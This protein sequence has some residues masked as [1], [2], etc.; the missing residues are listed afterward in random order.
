M[1]D[2]NVIY[3][4]QSGFQ[5]GDSTVNQLVDIYNTIISSLDKGKDVRF[6]FCDISKAFDKVWHKGLLSKL[7]TYG[8]SG[9]ILGWIENYL[10][11]R[12][13]KVVIDGFSSNHETVNAG[14]PQGSVLGPFLFLLY[15]NDICDDLVNNIRLFA[16][17]TSLYAIVE[18]GTTN[19]AQS[20]TNDLDLVDKWSKDWLVDFNPNKTVNVDFSRKN[21]A[22]PPIKFGENSPLIDQNIFHTHLGL[23]FQ[24][25]PRGHY[26]YN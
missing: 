9:N 22:Y 25:A 6:I 7:K 19:V 2:N 5:P 13:Q 24:R 21:K 23:C 3:K 1:N 20:L 8:V 4:Y 11:D 26:I 16:N 17:D 12:Q 10:C 18:N 15:I 14:V